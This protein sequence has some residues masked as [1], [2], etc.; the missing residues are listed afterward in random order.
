MS[1]SDR[2]GFKKVW[3]AMHEEMTALSRAG[4]LRTVPK[5]GHNIQRDQPR[6]V[7]DAVNEMVAKA[8]ERAPKP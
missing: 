8:R 2:I 1:A 7:I 4:V 3:I 6:A 5:A